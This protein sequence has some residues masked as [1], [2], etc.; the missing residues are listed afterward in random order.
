MRIFLSG[1]VGRSKWLYD[2]YMRL[3]MA[4]GERQEILHLSSKIL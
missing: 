3:Y 1:T 4:G 2:D